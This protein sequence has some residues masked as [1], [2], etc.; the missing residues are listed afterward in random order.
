MSPH[1]VAHLTFLLIKY[2]SVGPNRCIYNYAGFGRQRGFEGWLQWDLVFLVEMV[3]IA[4]FVKV[5]LYG[6]SRKDERLTFLSLDT[7]CHTKS[8]NLARLCH[9]HLLV[10]L[11]TCRAS[12]FANLS[13]QES[14]RYTKL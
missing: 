13:I 2:L 7:T 3:V 9:V 10:Q 1:S 4:S 12:L 6:A 14:L 11:D 5:G 8:H